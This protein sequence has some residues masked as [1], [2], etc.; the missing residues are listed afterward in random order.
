MR[1]S[2]RTLFLFLLCFTAGALAESPAALEGFDAF[3]EGVMKDWDVPG[4]AIGIVQSNETIYAKGFGYRD[5]KKKLPVT[6]NTL[7]AIGS[8]T[9]AFTCTL[10]GILADE[11]KLEWDAPVRQYVP[12]FRLRDP[13]ATELATPR[14]L[15]THRTGLPRHD[16]V[17]FNNNAISR[18]ELVQRLAYLEPSHTFRQK[19]QYNNLM[20]VTA[21]YLVETITGQSWEEN[22][23]ERIFSPLGM[24]GSNFSV[25]DAQGAADFALPYKEKDDAPKQIPFRSIDVVGPAGSIESSI[26]DML[27]WLRLN[28]NQGKCGDR[29]IIKPATLAEIH[30]PQMATGASVERPDI[31]QSTYCLG[32]GIETYRGHR[33]LGHGGGID[34]FITQV[35]I[36]PDDGLGVVVFANM[37]GTSSCTV[38]LRHAVD[39]VLGLPAVDWRV[40]MLAKRKKGKETDKEAKDN[41]SLTRKSGTTPSHPL[42]D[43]AGEYE[44]QGYGRLRINH[45]EKLDVLFNGMSAALEHWH[46]DV[47]NCAEGSSDDF[48]ANH[49]FN[50]ATDNDGTVASVA[51]NFESAVDPILFKRQINRSLF[52]TN[53]LSRFV[54]QFEL[55]GF[56]LN[57]SVAGTGL[58]LAIPGEPQYELIPKLDGSFGV[59]DH[60]E[61]VLRFVTDSENHVSAIRI[62]RP[63]GTVTAPKRT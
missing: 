27:K 29:Q 19:F 61:F 35:A 40:E 48:L 12:E 45:D 11:G 47:F 41:K 30:S 49:K 60:S 51:V 33:L 31:S 10:I 17:W 24:P 1:F 26:H 38:L 53:Y 36:L 4:L 46:Y 7:F 18:R 44:H 20:Y 5:L 63:G 22:I 32:W 59:K 23:R 9:K 54:G 21:G 57:I 28:L 58:K 62:Q 34:G 2:F 50:F 6:T 55:S 37:D 8:T 52:D 42:A 14:D 39:R 16:G 15:V 43:Y 3:I 25:R 13:H 56:T